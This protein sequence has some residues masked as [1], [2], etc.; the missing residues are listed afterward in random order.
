MEV[1]DESVLFRRQCHYSDHLILRYLQVFSQ[2]EQRLQGSIDMSILT[3]H[4]EISSK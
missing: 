2:L 3:L 4:N 1:T